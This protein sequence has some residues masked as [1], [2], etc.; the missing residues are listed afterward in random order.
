M[1]DLRTAALRALEAC[2]QRLPLQGQ[3]AI[4]DELNNLRTALAEPQIDPVD[5]YRKGFI[6]GQI[7]M[8]DRDQAQPEQEPELATVGPDLQKQ[9]RM[10]LEQLAANR[11]RRALDVDSTRRLL[12]A[13]SAPG[14]TDK[15]ITDL[16][17]SAWE[18]GVSCEVDDVRWGEDGDSHNQW[19]RD[20]T[21]DAATRLH[22]AVLTSGKKANKQAEFDSP[23]RR[24]GGPGCDLKCCQPVEEPVAKVELMMT[25]GNAGLATRIVEIDDRLR[26]R[27][28]PGQLLYTAPPQRKPLPKHNQH[29]VDVPGYGLMAVRLVRAVERAHGVKE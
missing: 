5:E 18:W 15:L 4:I 28:R 25:G 23:E 11:P 6:A 9:A 3:A 22:A 13:I 7:D 17:R 27:L 8:R 29:C 19:L 20:R 26:E 21:N 24:C 2:E 16:I 14:E 10:L 12:E 1:S